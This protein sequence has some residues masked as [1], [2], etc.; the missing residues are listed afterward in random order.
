MDSAIEVPADE[1]I[2]APEL[3]RAGL[4]A[5]IIAGDIAP[6][7]QLR[8]DEIAARFGTSRI[9][10]REAL[11]QLSVEGLV[12]FLPNRGAIV[13]TYSLA[14]L[15]EVMEIRI[16]L[17]TRALRLAIPHMVEEDIAAAGAILKDYDAEPRPEMWAQMNWQ[18][19]RLIY[20]PCNM[21]RLLEL[22]ESNWNHVSRFTRTRVSIA[23]GKES[24]NREHWK[25]LEAC[26]A[27]AI[28]KAV[29]LLEQHIGHTQKSLQ[30]TM[31]RI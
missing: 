1:R 5:A 20:V 22:I 12:D 15:M 25:I 8:Q 18:F 10:V 30:S 29:T 7:T 19:H 14:D 2:P 28:D 4:R 17:E 26:Q 9:P 21:P 16:G 31:R 23:A 13:K 6:G 27:G 3:V 11:K 24:P